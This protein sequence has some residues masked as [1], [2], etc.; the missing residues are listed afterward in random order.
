MI[1]TQVPIVPKV[2]EEVRV[3]KQ[4]VE[5]ERENL[6]ELIDKYMTCPTLSE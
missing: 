1:K 6:N 4:K 5:I 2:C 3:L